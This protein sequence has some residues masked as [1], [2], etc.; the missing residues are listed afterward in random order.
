MI[1]LL[2]KSLDIV[3]RGL[4][5]GDDRMALRAAGMVLRHSVALLTFTDLE[6]RIAELEQRIG[7]KT[8]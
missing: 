2:Q 1:A 7:G 6:R 3:E 5:S 8:K 4:D